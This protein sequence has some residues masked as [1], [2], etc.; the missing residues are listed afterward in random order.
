MVHEVVC[1]IILASSSITALIAVAGLLSPKFHDTLLQC[2]GLCAVAFGGF[3][4]TLQIYAH[5]VAQ[6]SGI[7]LES[8]GIALYSLATFVKYYRHENPATVE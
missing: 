7:A 1:W 2:L 8:V 3:I 4:I 6:I 5:G